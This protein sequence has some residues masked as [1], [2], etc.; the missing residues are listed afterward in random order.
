MGLMMKGNA[1]TYLALFALTV[2][3]LAARPAM[4]QVAVICHKDVPQDEI[5]KKQL[6]DFYVG[7]ILQWTDGTKIILIDQK[8]KGP[9]RERFFDFLGKSSARMKSIWM[10]NMLSGE[11]DPPLTLDNDQE[12]LEKVASTPG[13]IAFISQEAVDDSVKLLLSIPLSTE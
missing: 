8:D 13:C 4:G 10:K 6:L 5:D 3:L 12:I 7:D 11:S 9:V 2:L 1:A